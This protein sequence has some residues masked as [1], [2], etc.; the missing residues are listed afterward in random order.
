MTT[1]PNTERLDTDG[2]PV[3]VGDQPVSL[4][5]SL[6]PAPARAVA[7]SFTEGTMRPD[8][9]G[10]PDRVFLKLENIRTDKG[11][12]VFDVGVRP[13]PEAPYVDVGSVSL[14][15]VAAASSSRGP[16]GGAGMTKVLEV[17][18]AVDAMTAAQR[19]SG[20]L[21]IRIVP[22]DGNWSAGGISVGQVS[23]VRR[24]GQ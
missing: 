2:R 12:G 5:L 8:T 23:L 11:S 17:T 15:G 20:K 14:F 19:Q 21:D 4:T 7:N 22:R 18:N 24:S 10:E 16:H 9:P 3:T 13:S 6:A 1:R